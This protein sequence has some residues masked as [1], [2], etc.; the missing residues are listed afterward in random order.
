MVPPRNP[1]ALAQAVRRLA[2]DE[3]LRRH[4]RKTARRRVEE[5]YDIAGVVPRIEEFYRHLSE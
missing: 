2:T 1:A 3:S 5:F 4:L